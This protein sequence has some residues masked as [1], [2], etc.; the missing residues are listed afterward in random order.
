MTASRNRRKFL[1][2]TVAL[3]AAVSNS[4]LRAESKLKDDPDMLIIGPKPGYSPQI[5]TLVSMMTAMR[6][7]V[8]AS[9]RGL[10]QADLDY[11]LDSK[12]NTIGALLMHL[13]ATDAYYHLKTFEGKP[14]GSWDESIKQRWDVPMNLGQPARQAIKG[15]NLEYYLG[16]L[17]ETR[18]KTFGEFR[19]RDDKWLLSLDKVNPEWGR[20]NYYFEWFH[21]CEH[22]S[23][24]NGQ[25]KFIKG[26]L[27]GAKSEAAPQ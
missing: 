1:E 8:L 15:H 19:K 25:I 7:Q 22:E 6:A 16:I 18:E 17:E 3:T 13:A 27:P 21:V 26:R 14:W 11:L 10:S 2:S 4:T 23:N 20:L 5:G 9:T 24:H 12:A